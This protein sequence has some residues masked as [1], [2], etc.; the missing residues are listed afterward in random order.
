LRLPSCCGRGPS[1]TGAKVASRDSDRRSSS[2]GDVDLDVGRGVS[3]DVRATTSP[4]STDTSRSPSGTVRLPGSSGRFEALV[5]SS[6][7]GRVGRID[8]KWGEASV[9]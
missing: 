7:A 2:T 9:G 8:A 3:A 1:T 4:R 6:S 5:S